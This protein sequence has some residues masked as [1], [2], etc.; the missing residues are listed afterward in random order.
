MKIKM[1][2]SSRRGNGWLVGCV[3]L[4]GIL[5]G[6]AVACA[7]DAGA[8]GFGGDSSTSSFDPCEGN[9]GCSTNLCSIDCS[10]A[11]CCGGP[12][13][14]GD[15]RCGYSDELW[16][17]DGDRGCFE[18]IPCS[19]GCWSSANGSPASCI[20]D[21]S[22]EDIAA[23]YE[24]VV[25]LDSCSNPGQCVILDGHCSYGLGG[26]YHTVREQQVSQADLDELADAW[27]AAGCTGPVCDCAPTPTTG[28]CV[29]GHCVAP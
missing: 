18:Q 20:E 25:A 8:G 2:A 5:I 19:E 6:S 27:N 13:T 10:Q 22:C 26:C 28:S 4:S 7:G 24:Y 23:A 11:C 9:G 21:M 15:V 3:L 16:R 1:D 14:D 29:D 12:C 17:C